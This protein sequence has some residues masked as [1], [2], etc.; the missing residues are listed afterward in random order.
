VDPLTIGLVF[1]IGFAASFIGAISGGGGLIAIPSLIFLGLPP[2]IAIAT[3]KLGGI[4]HSGA[5]LIKYWQAKKIDWKVVPMML[6]MAVIGS[7]IGTQIL[8]EIN[9]DLLM[10]IVGIILLISLVFIQFKDFGL[11]TKET[12]KKSKYIGYIIYFFIAIYGAFFGGGAAIFSVLVLSHF[13]GLSLIRSVATHKAPQFVAF[14]ISASIYAWAGYINYYFAVP[15]MIGMFSG[16]W[17]GAHTAIKKGNRFV[18]YL[19]IFV[20][21]TSAIKLLF[22]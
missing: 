10:K 4:P 16:G 15:L 11:A 1:L 17:T 13:M 9:K 18:K 21:I 3:S 5:P 6:I 22:F 7:I 14:I 20:V 12:S 2:H 8:I 19:L